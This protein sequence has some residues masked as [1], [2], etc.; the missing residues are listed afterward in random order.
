MVRARA[1]R[2]LGVLL[3]V[4]APAVAL[5]HKGHRS[6]S[7]SPSPGASAVPAALETASPAPDVSGAAA[8]AG[9][10]PDQAPVPVWDRIVWRDAFTG[11]LHNKIVHFPL[12]LGLAGAVLFL[13]SPRWPDYERAGRLLL[14]LAALFAVGAYFSG[15]AQ[16]E[17]FE[18]SEVEELLELHENMGITTGITLWAGVLLGAWPRGRRWL[19]LYGVLLIVLLSVTG[20]LGGLLSHGEL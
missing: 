10:I 17:P 14:L 12:A 13:L 3:A 16:E 20:T 6:P 9:A 18:G 15:Q 8:V 4:M 2:V 1:S 7:P 11:H 5:A 19:R